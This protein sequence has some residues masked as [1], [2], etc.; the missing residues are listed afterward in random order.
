MFPNCSIACHHDFSKEPQ[1]NKEDFAGVQFVED[2]LS[3]SWGYSSIVDAGIKAFRLLCESI[4][5]PD[6]FYLISETDYPIKTA[7]YITRDLRD[8]EYDVFITHRKVSSTPSGNY[9]EQYLRS[10]Y[11]GDAPFPSG[12]Q[13]FAGEQWFTANLKAVRKLL[14][15]VDSEPALIEHY[16]KQEHSKGTICP[17]ESYYQTVFCNATGIKVKN[18]CLRYIDWLENKSGPKILGMND[19]SSMLFSNAHFARKFDLDK[20]SRLIDLLERACASVSYDAFMDVKP[21]GKCV[22]RPKSWL[23]VYSGP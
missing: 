6:W 14:Q 12:F 7:S 13:C 3:P 17:D 20:D 4:D 19:L 15:T 10:R 21:S 9:W 16:R 23:E 11:I 18:D 22:W 8:S 2:Y 1:L 5:P